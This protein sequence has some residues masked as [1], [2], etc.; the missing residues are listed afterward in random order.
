[1]SITQ[2]SKVKVR[3]G[4]EQNLPQ[5]SVGELAWSL[6]T[7]RL[8]IGN[9]D[10]ANGA[11]FPGNTEII[12]LPNSDD[13]FPT[14]TPISGIPSGNINGNNTVFTIPTI[15]MA[16]TLLVWKNFPLIPNVGYTI[17]DNIITFAE[18]PQPATEQKPGDNIYF[19]CWVQV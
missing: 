7:Q 9:G 16:N 3:S 1:M 10:V 15:P 4:L 14:L 2:K 13:V 5:L 18:A 19:Q 8:W 12:T 17:S 11:P 6:D